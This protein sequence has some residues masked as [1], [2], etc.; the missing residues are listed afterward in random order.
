MTSAGIPPRTTN[1]PQLT[2]PVRWK[3]SQTCPL[4]SQSPP[5]RR[6]QPMLIRSGPDSERSSPRRPL[7]VGVSPASQRSL[8]AFRA[9][10]VRT[11]QPIRAAGLCSASDRSPCGF[12]QHSVT[13]RFPPLFLSAHR[14]TAAATVP[15]GSGAQTMDPYITISLLHKYST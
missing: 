5:P 14:H 13:S 9:R 4:S 15:S 2:K 1:P 3:T 12:L 7:R 11:L 8:R 6:S 10:L